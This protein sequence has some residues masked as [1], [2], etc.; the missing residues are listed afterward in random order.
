MAAA[1]GRSVT[2]RALSVSV[3]AWADDEPS[4]SDDKRHYRRQ[5][6]YANDGEGV[7]RLSAAVSEIDASAKSVVRGG[8]CARADDAD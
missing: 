6:R 5:P 8:D 2:W 1:V 7:K 3:A 4:E